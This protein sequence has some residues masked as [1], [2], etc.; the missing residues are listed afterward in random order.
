MLDAD[1]KNMIEEAVR[2]LPDLLRADLMSR[3]PAVRKSAE[4]VVSTKIALALAEAPHAS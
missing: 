4:E 2:K 3:D 1:T